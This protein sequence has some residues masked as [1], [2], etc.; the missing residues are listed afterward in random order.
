MG[1]YILGDFQTQLKEFKQ[2]YP[3]CAND[4]TPLKLE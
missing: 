2:N 4:F 3:A 1:T